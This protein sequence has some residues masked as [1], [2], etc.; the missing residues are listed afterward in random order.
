M[1]SREI[2]EF[3]SGYKKKYIYGCGKNGRVLCT[4]LGEHDVDIDGFIV[5]KI[6]N[7]ECVL[8][9]RVLSVDVF[10]SE[11]HDSCVL[12]GVGDKNRGEVLSKVKE[13]GIKDY[14]EIPSKTLLG[15]ELYTD[16]M[17]S[18]QAKKST[19]VL[20][21]HRVCE[22]PYDVWKLAVRPDE[23]EKQMRFLKENYHIRRLSDQ[24]G[25][26][27]M[28]IAVTFDDGYYDNY[29]YAYPILKKYEIPAIFFV[30]TGYIDN[31]K[32]FWSDILEDIVFCNS[33]IPPYILM[34]GIKYFLVTDEDKKRFCYEIHPYLKALLPEEREIELI[35]IAEA[36]RTNI[37]FKEEYRVMTSSEIQEIAQEGLVEI[38]GHSVTHSQM[39]ALPKER[40]KQEI[41][42]SKKTLEEICKKQVNCFAYPYG[43]MA[44][45]DNHTEAIAKECGFQITVTTSPGLWIKEKGNLG[46][47]RNVVSAE[48]DLVGLQKTIR[49]I[50]FL[51][52]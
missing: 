52:G 18:I 27:G 51:Y 50:P 25:Y 7:E 48:S 21:Y 32:M 41:L 3:C 12:I 29:V 26:S 4:F 10:V 30:S 46:I 6:E 28:S 45:Y 23:F 9:K 24:D 1:E 20:Y 39:S 47:P 38:G 42:V 34:N 17:E 8:G 5:S 19:C 2:I 33:D 43:S 31:K 13:K 37:R 16:F 15:L 11:D 22:R 49:K 40:Q 36:L 44:D 35:K 14:L